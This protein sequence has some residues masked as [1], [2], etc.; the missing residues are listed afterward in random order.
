MSIVDPKPLNLKNGMTNYGRFY[1]LGYVVAFFAEASQ[2][3]QARLQLLE[4][5][6]V[7]D[8]LISTSGEELAELRQDIRDNRPIWAALVSKFAQKDRVLD[9]AEKGDYHVLL[10]YAPE[11]SQIEI[12][13]GVLE[14]LAV[15]AQSYS[16]MT[17]SQLPM[18]NGTAS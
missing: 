11:Q 18:P 3:E 17:F 13:R 4:L 10:I 15:L 14:N 5:K 6:W 9:S 2:R 8:E 7:S 16:S 1:P 12:V